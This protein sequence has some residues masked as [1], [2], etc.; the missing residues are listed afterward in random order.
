M[1]SPAFPAGDLRRRLDSVSLRDAHQLSRRIDG[2]RRIKDQAKQQAAAAQVTRAVEEAEARL[3]A[4]RSRV[5]EVTFPEELPVTARRE[6]IA[7]A[8]TDHQVVVLAGETGSGKTTQLPK[9]CLEAGRGVRGLIGHTQPRR[10]AARTVADRIAEE[11][12]GELGGAIGYQVRFTDRVGPDTLVKVMTDGILLNEIQRDK[13]LRGYDTLI[14]DEA[15]ERSLNVDFIIGYLRHLLP[16]RPDLKLIITSATID[17]G[18]FAAAFDDAPIIEVSGRTYP[19]EVRYRPL[20]D[21]DRPDREARDQDVA[22]C[23]AVRELVREGP[24][25]ILV[26]CSGEREIRDATDAVQRMGLRDTEVLPLYARLSTAEQH[27]VFAPHTG[28]RVVL[29]TNVAETSLTVPGIRYVVDTGTARISRYS[30]RLKVQRLPI[31]PISQA[32]ANQRSGRCGR[33]SDGIAIRLYSEEDY[34]SRPEFTDPEILR[35]NLASVILSMTALDLGDL[36]DFPFIDPPDTRAVRDGVDLLLELDAL[37]PAKPG[38]RTRHRLTPTGRTLSKLPLDP[39]LAR[40]V[41]EADRNGVLRELLVIVSGLSVQ[42]PRERP[43]DHQQAADAK[44]ARFAQPD[45]DFLAYLALWRYL[46]EQKRELSGSAFRRMCRD[47]YLHYLRIR[48]WQDV[49]TQLKAVCKEL[50]LELGAELGEETDATAV[51]QSILAG[52]LSHIGLRN[53]ET[54]AYD[55]A[56]GATFAIFPGSSLFKKPPQWVMAAEL[57]ETTRLWARECARIDP[58]WAERLGAHLVKRSYSEPHWERKRAAVVALEKVTLYGVPLVAGRRV[59]Y[60][61]IDP[62]TSRELFIRHALVE[63]DWDTHHPFFQANRAMLEDVEEL[64]ERVRRR[65]IRVDDETLFEFYDQ[66][67]GEEVVSGR[68]FDTWWK[69][70][71]RDQPD[72]LDF[73]ASLLVREDTAPVSAEEFPDEWRSGEV[74]LPLSYV[75]EPGSPVDG[76]T[77]DVPLAQLNQVDAADFWWHVPGRREELVA[78]LIKT[79]P[80]QW[81]RQ[82]VPAPDHARAVAGDLVPEGSVV[83]AVADALRRRTGVI[84]PAD[85][86]DLAAVPDHLRMNF[87]VVDGTTEVATGK[88]LDELR[89]RLRPK[90]RSALAKVAVHV[91]ERGLTD[92][93]IGDLPRH[94]EQRRGSH[95]VHGYP[96]LVDEGATVGV[97][98][99]EDEAQQAHAMRF[100]TRRLLQLTLPS[101]VVGIVKRLDNR[102]KLTL[103][104]SPYP[105]VPTMLADCTASAIDHLMVR[106]GGPAW[107]RAAFER[108]AAGVRDGLHATT[109]EDVTTVATVLGLWTQVRDRVTELTAPA[110]KPVVEDLRAQLSWLVHDGFV[111][112]TGHEQLVHL[113]R[114]LRAIG[115]RLDRLPED[116]FRDDRS[117]VVVQEIEDHWDDVFDALPPHRRT[118]PDTR[119]VRWMIEELRVSLFA[120]NLGTAQPVS[121]KRIRNALAALHHP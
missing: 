82:F 36:A 117:M 108:L 17:P 5:P 69:R 10:L 88:D 34:D 43:A 77:V 115:R 28:R 100:G 19:V 3:A 97:R 116:P 55:G 51:A 104:A 83:T 80:K 25:D 15:H 105:D 48:E 71:R 93:T 9:I 76:V 87:R 120:Q 90:L 22:I 24:G 26:F 94:V 64:E 98:V 12:G 40:M 30:Q 52:L 35:T 81:R 50:G 60:G 73:E 89:E 20:V 53:P 44:H 58:A 70:V 59:T 1:P 102:T 113:P 4:R 112:E 16:R 49:H 103:A 14:L 7:R 38:S 111:S 92:W 2:I 54:R 72:L 21:P 39:R 23:D 78:A 101:P 79:L 107:D 11:V 33:T 85:A 84:V 32:S 27:K 66:R 91:E 56:R 74:V 106:H 99:F 41:I 86:F 96:A 119:A 42:D 95:V 37:E 6:E 57:V 13:M 46:R 18:R 62:V 63:G 68:H 61:G 75:F 65:D 8:I 67:V 114:Y 45:S 121:P 118:D 109:Y 29:S 47:E 31:E 110:A